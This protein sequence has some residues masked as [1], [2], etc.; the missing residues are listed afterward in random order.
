MFEKL[1]IHGAALADGAARR[2]RRALAEAL[3]ADPP[4]GVNVS[5]EEEGVV[6]SGPGLARRLALDPAL[7]WLLAG[8]RR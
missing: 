7:R 8:R 1:T 4:A 5:E 6:L 3:A 2:R